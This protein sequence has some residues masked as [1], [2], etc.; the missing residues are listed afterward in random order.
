[1]GNM[2][3]YAKKIGEAVYQGEGKNKKQGPPLDICSRQDNNTK[4]YWK[5]NKLKRFN[6]GYILDVK[7]IKRESVNY[8]NQ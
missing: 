6:K 3:K 7:N 2:L 5:E 1:M 8:G 4:K